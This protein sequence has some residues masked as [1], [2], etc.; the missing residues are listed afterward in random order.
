MAKKVSAL[1]IP[2]SVDPTAAERGLKRIQDRMNQ[3]G[4]AGGQIGGASLGGPIGKLGGLAGVGGGVGMA[5]SGAML[6]AATLA[7]PFM[8]ADKLLTSMAE[9]ANRAKS[10]IAEFDSSGKSVR[11]SIGVVEPLARRLA[12]S[13]DRI[14][15]SAANAKGFWDTFWAAGADSQGRAGAAEGWASSLMNELK[16]QTAK[17]GAILGGKSLEEANILSDIASAPSDAAAQSY[18]PDLKA[19]EKRN[20]DNSGIGNFA[21][22]TLMNVPTMIGDVTRSLFGSPTTLA[23]L[24][25]LPGIASPA[26]QNA[27]EAIASPATKTAAEAIA[28]PATKTAAE[29]IASPATQNA[30]EA[31]AGRASAPLASPVNTAN[32]NTTIPLPEK[33]G[34][35]SSGMTT[36]ALRYIFG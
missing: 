7:A 24:A 21:Q 6:S 9:S 36:D 13:S 28:S 26:T 11:D 15:N 32:Q 4:K 31:I 34:A 23:P 18:M 5:A 27:A 19:A 12:E 25:N 30:A 33:S 3:L 16:G 8:I 22:A 17:Y 1:N 20:K 10:A 14:N 35:D 2:V 29:A